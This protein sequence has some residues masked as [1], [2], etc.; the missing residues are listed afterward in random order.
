MY[1]FKQP[2]D[3]SKE[4][5]ET[6]ISPYEIFSYYIGNDFDSGQVMISPLRKNDKQPSFS[7]FHSNKANTLLFKDFGVNESGDC[8]KFVQLLFRCTFREALIRINIDF[9]LKLWFNDMTHSLDKYQGFIS[10]K[11][12]LEITD[13][14]PLQVKMQNFTYSDLLYWKQYGIDEKMLKTF[15][16]IS[17]SHLFYGNT[18]IATSS[19]NCPMFAYVFYKDGQHSF[20]IYRPLSKDKR[21]KWFSNTNRTILQGWDQLPSISNEIV[22][23]KSLKDV[24]VCTLLGHTSLSMQTETSMI[25]DTVMD[26]IRVRFNEVYVIQDFDYAGV[27]G[28]NKMRKM[29][30]YVHPRFI[31]H[32]GNRSNGIKDISDYMAKYGK[33][34]TNEF[35][36]KLLYGTI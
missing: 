31:Q 6:K 20:K 16:V 17:I 19:S 34:K 36:N 11:K 25:K 15:N 12:H 7:V 35:L 33:E 13:K 14:L 4:A 8:Y 3:L 22:I 29:Y 28:V 24:M 21:K 2:E 32:L 10:N 18:V 26:E 30:F 1:D 27:K 23:T 5:I 9:N